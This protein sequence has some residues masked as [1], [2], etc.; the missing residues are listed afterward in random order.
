MADKCC[1]TC[2]FWKLPDLDVRKQYGNV[3]TCATTTSELIVPF[4]ADGVMYRTRSYEGRQCAAWI[5]RA[6]KARE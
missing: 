6:T 4:W 5:G 1:E 2:S 3:G